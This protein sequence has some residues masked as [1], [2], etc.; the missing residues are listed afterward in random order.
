MKIFQITHGVY[1]LCIL[2][3]IVLFLPFYGCN[4]EKNRDKSVVSPEVARPE[5]T[6]PPKTEQ[7]SVDD[8]TAELLGPATDEFAK[9]FEDSENNANGQN[10]ELRELSVDQALQE[11]YRKQ[12]IP[13]LLPTVEAAPDATSVPGSPEPTDSKPRYTLTYRFTPQEIMQWDVTHRINKKVTYSG[14]T[15]AI[16][17][18]SRIVRQWHIVEDC[19]N[20]KFKCEHKIEKM[21]LEQR[22]EGEDPIVY[23]SETDLVVPKVFAIFGT[24]KTIGPVLERFEI[25]PQGLMTKKEKLVREFQGLEA[26]SKVLVPFPREPVAVGDSWTIPYTIY[27]KGRDETVRACQALQKF[28]LENVQDS[29]ATI[30]FRAILLSVVNDPVLEGQLAEKIFT[31]TSR[32]D[33]VSGRTLTTELNFDRSVP[34]AMGDASHLDYQCHVIETSIREPAQSEQASD[35]GANTVPVPAAAER[36]PEEHEE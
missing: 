15:Q 28:T 21:I 18:L 23:N 34:L 14:K 35:E 10:G 19:G 2:S 31:G 1:F 32:F 8:W 13:T 22:T 16:E 9:T 30:S 11:E 26:D 20:G 25:D 36:P 17:T 24:D 12:V 27:L 5:P 6:Q 33:M 29:L 4:G 7:P 3:S